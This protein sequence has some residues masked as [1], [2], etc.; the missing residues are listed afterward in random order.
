MVTCYE[1]EET[2]NEDDLTECE[3]CCELVCFDC[4]DA[5]CSSI[6]VCGCDGCESS[7]GEDN[8]CSD[9]D[10]ERCDEC[11]IV[12][13]SCYAASCI[14]SECGGGCDGCEAPNG[15]CEEHIRKCS[16]SSC[17]RE[18]CFTSKWVPYSRLRRLWRRIFRGQTGIGNWNDSGCSAVK[19]NMSM[20]A[21][22][23][24]YWCADHVAHECA[25]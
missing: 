25:V 22:C 10:S 1:C 2:F 23:E 20:C 17:S 15:F 24:E 14:S 3:S 5:G 4:F 18:F 16:D 21:S 19:I 12:C 13:A 7:A 8:Y 9:C 11:A 6:S